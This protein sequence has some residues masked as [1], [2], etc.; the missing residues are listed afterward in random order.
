MNNIMDFAKKELNYV[1]NSKN[2]END[3]S[4]KIEKSPRTLVTSVM[5]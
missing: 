5:S 1:F 4:S 3:V 2:D